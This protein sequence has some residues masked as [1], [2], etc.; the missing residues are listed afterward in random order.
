MF[1]KLF[2]LNLLNLSLSFDYYIFTRTWVPAFCFLNKGKCSGIIPQK[3][4]I[5]GLWP[6]YDNGSWPQYCPS[7][8]NNISNNQELN[9]ILPDLNYHWSDSL[10]KSNWPLWEHEWQK[11]GTCAL[12]SSYINTCYDYFTTAL[13]LDLR[14]NVNFRLN[15]EIVPNNN[16]SFSRDELESIFKSTIFCKNFRGK[17][18]LMEIQNN[19]SKGLD[20]VNLV[21]KDDSCGSRVYLIA[22]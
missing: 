19:I 5:H 4:S 8:I 1:Y 22:S 15:S 20:E 6:T 12:N 9:N 11:H 16:I 18:I 13:W 14:L 3:F 2:L 7:K 17:S 10:N 21:K